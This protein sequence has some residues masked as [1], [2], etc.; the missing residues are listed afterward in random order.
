MVDISS[1]IISVNY[2]IKYETRLF[3][4]NKILVITKSFDVPTLQNLDQLL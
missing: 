2:M 3:K 1:L 4:D